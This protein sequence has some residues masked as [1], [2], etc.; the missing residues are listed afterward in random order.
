MLFCSSDD[1]GLISQAEKLLHHCIAGRSP[2]WGCR[3][4]HHVVKQR[5]ILFKLACIN[6]AE[7]QQIYQNDKPSGAV[8]TSLRL[9]YINIG[10][11]APHS[12]RPLPLSTPATPTNVR[13]QTF[14]KPTSS[15]IKPHHLCTC[16]RHRIQTDKRASWRQRIRI[17]WWRLNAPPLQ[18]KRDQWSRKKRLNWQSLNAQALISPEELISTS[19]SQQQTPLT[20]GSL[21]NGECKE[22]QFPV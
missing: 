8:Q 7:R 19:K 17:C 2:T 22:R 6:V 3:Y 5:T 20:F 13:I 16:E 21:Q 4:C 15:R 18:R 12:Y 11:V 9:S 10:E 1:A 14:L